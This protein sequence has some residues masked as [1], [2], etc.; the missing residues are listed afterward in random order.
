VLPLHIRRVKGC[1]RAIYAILDGLGVTVW[2]V[3]WRVRTVRLALPDGLGT[4]DDR[5]AGGIR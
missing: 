4:S 3:V 2:G 5:T 1:L